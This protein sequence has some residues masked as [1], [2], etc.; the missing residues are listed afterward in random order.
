MGRDAEQILTVPPPGLPSQARF[1]GM[2][3]GG[4]ALGPGGQGAGQG[5]G[6]GQLEP[7]VAQARAGS[8]LC[9]VSCQPQLPWDCAPP[10]LLIAVRT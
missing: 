3:E 8:R 6:W 10:A 2:S 4:L 7:W 9:A 1:W 5:G